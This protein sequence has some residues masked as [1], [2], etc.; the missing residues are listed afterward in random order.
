M[1]CPRIGNRTPPQNNPH[2][3]TIDQL[4]SHLWLFHHDGDADE[5]IVGDGEVYH[6]LPLRH[7]AV[8]T[9]NI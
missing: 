2:I 8:Q 9:L 5:V 4:I 3:F 7:H 1:H 6:V